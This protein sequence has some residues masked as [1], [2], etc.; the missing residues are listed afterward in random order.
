[1]KFIKLQ[2]LFP[3]MI[4]DQEEDRRGREW[5]QFY[6]GKGCGPD[7]KP[8]TES[9]ALWKGTSLW[10]EKKPKGFGKGRKRLLPRSEIP[11]QQEAAYDWAKMGETTRQNSACAR[12]VS[13]AGKGQAVR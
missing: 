9:I 2:L 13:D 6:N 11:A 5:V 10:Q 3:T 12:G 7:H 1:M 4:R 8:Q